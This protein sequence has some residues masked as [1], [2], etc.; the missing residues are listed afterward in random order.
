[1]FL[2]I[3]GASGVGKTTIL[4]EVSKRLSNDPS[5]KIF[6][7]DDMGMPNWDE[8]EDTKKWQEEATIAWID[9]LMAIAEKEGAHILFEGSTDM[10]F[11]VQG[12]EKHNFLDYKILLFDCSETTMKNRLK[13]RGQP[14][15]YTKDMIGWLNYLRRE[16]IAKD[17][18]IIKTDE[19]SVTEIGTEIIKRIKN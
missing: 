2:T 7:F 3:T 8:V 15:L 6:H 16:A 19:R 18:E 14:E 17:I 9:K 13:H 10:K 4:K 5:V 12:F 11:F 1:M